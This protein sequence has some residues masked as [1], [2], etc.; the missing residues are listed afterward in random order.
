MLL[1]LLSPLVFLGA[2]SAPP[3]APEAL[4][5]S[6]T[7][8]RAAHGANWRVVRDAETGFAEFLHGGNVPIGTSVRDERDAERIAETALVL[9]AAL[10]GVATA[11][12]HVER[13]L[14]LPLG[15]IGSTDKW[16]V[17]YAQRL[18]GLDVEGA[19]VN[20]LV[21]GVGRLLSVHSTAVPN[22]AN[23]A[24]QPAISP[25]SALGIA[26][27]DFLARHSVGSAD[28]TRPDLVARV[29]VM[30]G[31]RTARA[32]WSIDLRRDIADDAPIVE[33]YWID[34]LNGS[35]LAIE[36]Q[37]HHF[38]VTGTV[39]SK[40]TP[41]TVP[42]WPS[43]PETD[44]VVR[45]ARV[46]SSA[47][48]VTTDANG[49]FTFPGVNT[50]L[51]VTVTYYGTHADVQ[52]LAGAE[53]ALTQVV[54]ANTP[55]TL[56]MNAAP[57]D[58]VTAQANAMIGIS[59]IR[60]WIRA[61]NPSDVTMETRFLANVNVSGTCNAFFDGTSVRFFM[62]GGGCP[63]MSYSTIIGHEMGHWLNVLY[64]SGNSSD[65]IGEGNADVWAMYVYDDPIVGTD[66]FGVGSPLRTGLNNS[67]FCGDAS[68][69]CHG[70]AH[71]NGE[72]WMGAA[73]K[74]RNRLN[75][76]NGNALGDAI[77]NSV[78]LGWMN[79]YNQTQLRSIIETQ[80]LTLDDND[81]NL[82][83]G[84]PHYADIDG[85]FRDQ[86]FPGVTLIPLAVSG[87]TALTDTENEVGPYV[88]DANI[89][90]NFNPPLTAATLRWRVGAGAFQDVAMTP[91]GGD[92]YRAT[93]PGQ[94]DPALVQYY[95]HAVDSIAR[96][97][98][99]PSSA[100]EQL[101][102]FDV[103]T[104]NPIVLYTFDAGATGWTTGT[105]GDS[106][107]PESD[108]TLSVP[109][110]K[111]GLVGGVEWRD[112]SA[113]FSGFGCFGN[114]LGNGANDGAY[115]ANVHSYLRSPVLNLTGRDNVR[116]RFQ[117]WL[118]VDGNALDQARVLVNGVQFY[119]NPA[120]P[121]SDKAW[122][123]QEFDIS[124]VAANN[125][126]VQVEFRLRSNG[127]NH[128]GGWTLDDINLFSLTPIVV[129]CPTPTTYCI[130]APN[131]VGGGAQIG[132][133]GTG[134][135]VLNDLQLFVYACPANTTGLFYAGTS[136]LQTPFGNGFR[137]A[138]GSTLRLGLQTTDAFGDASQSVDWHALPGGAP[139][140]GQVRNFQFWYRNPAAGG[141]GFNLSNALSVTVCE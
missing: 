123:M 35:I 11:S 43:N 132:F 84:T 49:V 59:R 10:H 109:Q 118:S 48:T 130:G 115:S 67:P 68:P 119:V 26:G 69:G 19:Q 7:E 40:A 12:L 50:P 2:Q 13:A 91:L 114:D 131:T 136:A 141:A 51:S 3:P 63:N 44:Q 137:C 31:L 15:L 134:N 139:A 17:R 135:V 65:G 39:V 88:V 82:D 73:W 96:V 46:Q 32:A 111:G 18:G 21:D 117:S 45:F 116:L 22:V 76:T 93:I 71:A 77:A 87:V 126:S 74:V 129:P 42:D 78:F 110:G 5:I 60:D 107:N 38:D 121:R 25:E 83:N 56:T 125:P 55:T 6:L 41:G 104:L 53:F 75:Q 128:F 127:T 85:G 36:N 80:W 122:G 70:G 8:F 37:V 14:H 90:A 95:V 140:P 99:W 98:T 1:A 64:G 24:S 52:N 4:T 102:S 124:S 138:G 113:A 28:A 86:G 81:G 58:A 54:P 33:R 101:Q 108:W 66:F 62:A 133:S 9:T 72:P 120:A 89:S 61:I 106:S 92:A 57:T 97:A 16:T 30:D 94:N 34:A 112:P 20:V 103:G 29:L 23:I 105:V 79:S 27:D 100:P 47:G